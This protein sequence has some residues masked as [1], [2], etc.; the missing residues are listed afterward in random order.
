M[1]MKF[2]APVRRD[3][4]LIGGGHAHVEVLKRFGMKPEPGVRLNLISPDSLTP[5]S[6]MLPGYLAGH[7]TLKDAHIDVRTL[8]RFARARF[9]RAAATEIDLQ[10]RTVACV[11]HQPV[12]FDLLSIDIGST[13]TAA[14]LDGAE[15]AVA[16]KPVDRFL[17]RWQT[18]EQDILADGGRHRLVVV[19]AGAGGVEAALAL[20]FRVRRALDRAGK[21]AS[22]FEVAIVAQSREPLETHNG[23]VRKRMLRAL[24][25][26]GIAF[27][28]G[29]TVASI[30]SGQLESASGSAFAFDT[31]ILVTPASAADWLQ[32]TGLALDDAGFIKVRDT[33]QSVTD[34]A[35]FA[36]GDTSSFEPRRLPKSGVYAVRQGPLLADNL[37]RLATNNAPRPFRPQRRTLALISMGD[38][39]AALSYGPL[40]AEGDWAWRF[41]DWID[42][43]WMRKYQ[44]LPDMAA[45]AIDELGFDPMRCG[46][47]GAKVPSDILKRV[48]HRVAPNP[49]ASSVLIGLDAPDD[50][51]A[52]S[53]PR[54]KVLVQTVDQ[55]RAFIEDPHLF[56]RITANHCL[57]DI[58]AMGAQPASALA[59]ITLP[60][61]D[62]AKMEHD[63]EQLLSGALATLRGGRRRRLS[64]GIRA[65]VAK[66]R[67][68]SRSTASSTKRRSCA[69]A[70]CRPATP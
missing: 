65:R 40:T 62:D 36:A 5:Y 38:K 26:N 24:E 60:Y 9:Y 11:G 21:A 32:R 33:L 6:G 51:A 61:S 50:A 46:G 25:R 52:F 23:G 53:P 34:D 44:D 14:G 59:T 12:A 47:C 67:S 31:A 56:G 35:V 19:G 2:E 39:R 57:G 55:F 16:I 20:N 58:F 42:R 69:G 3:I 70:A 63:M 29:Q 8:A 66:W 17:D 22:K 54:G 10:N 13:P 18:I 68:V 1:P 27:H 48:L 49:S 41:K 30:K 64:V 43:R 37:R 45:E 4:V 7:Y 28:G 15:N